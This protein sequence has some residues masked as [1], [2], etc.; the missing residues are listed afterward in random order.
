M[1]RC[2]GYYRLENRRCDREAVTGTR[3]GDGDYAVCAYHFR[4]EG[5]FA[6]WQGETGIRIPSRPRL[7]RVA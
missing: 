2:E 4:S 3:T 5:P 7:R 6:R 1:S